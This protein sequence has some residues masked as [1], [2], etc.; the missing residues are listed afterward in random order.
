MPDA[1]EKRSEHA[2]ERSSLQQKLEE[3]GIEVRASKRG[4]RSRSAASRVAVTPAG[5]D[6]IARVL[7][8]IEVEFDTLDLGSVNAE[9]LRRFSAVFLNCSP[10]I[11]IAAG[12]DSLA[13]WVSEG[14]WLYASDWAGSYVQRVFPRSVTVAEDGNTGSLKAA[15]EH[16]HFREVLGTDQVTLEFDMGGWCRVTKYE[17]QNTEVFLMNSRTPLML[18]FKH[19]RGQVIFT[20]FHNSAQPGD[21][22]AKLLRF[23]IL[24]PIV[25]S[26]ATAKRVMQL[27]EGNI[28]RYFELGPGNE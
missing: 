13:R 7:K 19:G 12:A 21:T 6:D 11:K 17:V 18:S 23:L 2:I 26:T 4:A 5:Y 3:L 15:V 22:V 20:S 24:V 9:V 25:Q 16:A 1:P 10:A 8:Q 14:G 28:R 27:A